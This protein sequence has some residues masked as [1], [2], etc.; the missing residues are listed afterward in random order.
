M[1]SHR[2][3][4]CSS[5]LTEYVLIWCVWNPAGNLHALGVGGS[6]SLPHILP[7]VQCK[8]HKSWPSWESR[9]GPP[10]YHKN[11]SRYKKDGYLFRPHAFPQILIVTLR[12]A[13]PNVIRFCCCVAVI[14]L[15]YCFCG[16]IVLGPY[17]V[18][19]PPQPTHLACF[20]LNLQYHYF[21]TLG[22]SATK[23]IKHELSLFKQWWIC[24][25]VFFWKMCNKTARKKTGTVFVWKLVS[26]NGFGFLLSSDLCPWCQSACSPW[27]TAMTCSWRSQGCRRAARWCGYSA[28]CTSTPSSPSSST[29]CCHSSSHSSQEPMRPSR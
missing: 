18:K 7:E 27:S 13:F 12:A 29:W 1:Q 16:W 4:T 2:C 15:G 19:V 10:Q 26:W 11:T 3:E 28:K 25:F 14:Y 21:K 23:S 9:P 24:G 17:H 5:F 20:C 6:H 8:R 22:I